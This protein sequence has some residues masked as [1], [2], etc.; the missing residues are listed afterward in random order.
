MTCREMDWII[1]SSSPSSGF[2]PEAFEHIAECD[3]CRLLAAYTGREL[4]VLAAV[5][6]PNRA[7]GGDALQGPGSSA[8][9]SEGQRISRGIGSGVSGFSC[10][11]ILVARNERLATTRHGSEDRGS[12][13]AICLRRSA[14]LVPGPA[15]GAWK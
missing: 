14:G 4:P 13:A 10:D 1:T 6:N 3:R 12:G 9:S 2:P 7:H 15:D 8:A 11:R 5:R